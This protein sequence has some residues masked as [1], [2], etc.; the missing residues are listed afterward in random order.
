[1]SKIWHRIKYNRLTIFFSLVWR[2]VDSRCPGRIS[3]ETAW[4]VAMVLYP[5]GE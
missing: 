5:K 3:V 4:E 2:R 1:M